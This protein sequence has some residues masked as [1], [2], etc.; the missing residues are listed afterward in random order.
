MTGSMTGK[1][2][3]SARDEKMKKITLHLGLF[4]SSLVCLISCAQKADLAI[5]EESG[6]FTVI[7]NID[8]TKTTNDAKAT[9]WAVGDKAS[10]IYCKSGRNTYYHSAF[11]YTKDG[12]F[13]GSIT[14]TKKSNDWY[15]VYPYN[16]SNTSPKSVSVTVSS[17]QSQSAN[18]STSH[19]AGE[20]FPIFG[21]RKDYKT[22]EPIL[23]IDMANALAVGKIVITNTLDAPITV[24][25]IV[26]SSS[27]EIAGQ[28]SVD[29][30]SA[31]PVWTVKDGAGK[32][33]TLTVDGGSAI[34]S[35]GSGEFYLGFKPHTAT[36]E[37]ITVTAARNGKAAVDYYIA[38]KNASGDKF[39]SGTFKVMNVKYDESHPIEQEPFNLENESV[40]AFID[41]AQKQYTDT[42][43]GS[44]SIVSKYNGDQ[45]SSNRKDAPAPVTLSWTSSTS[46]VRTISVYN[47]ASMTDLEMSTTSSSNS[48][49]IRN[50]VPGSNYWYKVTSSSGAE[51]ASGTF[52]TE[53]RRRM[54]LVSSVRGKGRANNCRD[55]GGLKTTDGKTLKYGILFRGSNID[56][57]TD[58]EKRYILG[59]MNVGLDVDL[60]S[61]TASY[62]SEGEDGIATAHNPWTGSWSGKITY[63]NDGAFTGTF[64]ESFKVGAKDA[65]FTQMFTQILNTIRTGKAAYLHCHVGADRTGYVCLILE[66]ALGVSAKDCSIDFELTS[67]SVVGN[68][69]RTGDWSHNMCKD[70][71]KYINNYSKGKTYQEKA[72]NILLDYGITE[73]QLQEFKS[74]MLE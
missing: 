27:E 33:V 17:S 60:R 11:T 25:R 40:K 3:I 58:E 71:L 10:L 68:R 43:Y 20:N 54:L 72:W 1:K 19:L 63:C 24:S 74:I 32:S 37:S 38:R 36:S 49:D 41:E 50:L 59:Y 30:T 18:N 31:S 57:A 70:A 62:T 55:L 6:N 48:V 14:D 52:T 7:A 5:P 73:A 44:V 39:E 69:L 61:D 23:A 35:G 64:S 51:I 13:S 34:P 22:T 2:L 12:S 16:S 66:S 29:M 45:S 65:E 53:G 42:N 21:V 56:M 26:F 15:F 9:K 46:G 28:F 8:D 47:D 4:A 67:F